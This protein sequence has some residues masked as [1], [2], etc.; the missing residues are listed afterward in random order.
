MIIESIF[1]YA[2]IDLLEIIALGLFPYLS[3]RCWLRY[4]RVKHGAA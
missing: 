2:S 1:G 4:R 3:L